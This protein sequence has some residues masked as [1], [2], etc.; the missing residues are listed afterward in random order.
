MASVNVS[1]YLAALLQLLLHLLGCQV[2]VDDEMRRQ[3]L[4]DADAFDL[5]VVLHTCK[6]RGI[7]LNNV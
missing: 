4:A 1:H 5:I 6:P 7:S 3:E 2:D